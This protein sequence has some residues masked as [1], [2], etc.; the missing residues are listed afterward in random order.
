VV[1]AACEQSGRAFVPQ[2][3]PP[4]SL[5]AWLVQKPQGFVLHHRDSQKLSDLCQPN[6][7][8]YLTIGPEGGLSDDEIQQLKAQ[9]FSGLKMGPRIL[10]TETAAL[11]ALSMMQS[12]WGDF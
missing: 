2:V 4:L 3:L 12:H 10:R 8:Y 1:I 11:A 7:V 5:D 9:G 6:G